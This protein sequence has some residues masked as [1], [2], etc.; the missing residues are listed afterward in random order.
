[1]RQLDI[2]CDDNDALPFH[3]CNVVRSR[4]YI[5]QTFGVN[6]EPHATYLT[7]VLRQIWAK[8]RGSLQQRQQICSTADPDAQNPQQWIITPWAEEQV[9]R[10]KQTLIQGLTQKLAQKH[11]PKAVSSKG[12]TAVSDR[13]KFLAPTLRVFIWLWQLTE[14]FFCLSIRLKRLLNMAN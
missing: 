14:F 12:Q 1:M 8:E 9:L 3:T 6:F 11:T 7:A 2:A 13:G 5:P 4:L 10:Q